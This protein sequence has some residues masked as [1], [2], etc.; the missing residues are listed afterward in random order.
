MTR[1]GLLVLGL[2]ACSASAHAGPWPTGAG[3]LYAKLS[4]QRLRST[5]YAFPDGFETRI[6]E[7]RRDDG[8]LFFAYGLTDGVTLL[9]DVPYRS[10]DLADSPDE[11]RRV[12]G[13]GDLRFG[14]QVQLGRSGPW[15]FATRGLVQAPVGDET[16]SGGLQATGSGTWEAE[17]CLG[18]GRSLWGGKGYGLLELGHQY[19][20][21]GLRDGFV[22]NFQI[23]WNTT[24]RLVLAANFHG[25]EPYST[26]AGDRTAGSFVGV[27]DRVTYA[28]YG[29]TLILKA[30]DS[31]GV[32]L[33]V[34]GAF[35][36][37]NITK[38]TAFRV[39][40]FWQR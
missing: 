3:R 24:S 35:H 11:L 19:R 15:V 4:Y 1:R 5:V 30:S 40:V 13:I 7:F 2:L 36:T 20:G 17:A 37:R 31:L 18:A 29:P 32:Q 38:G 12:G 34:D 14:L 27:G 23:G 22:Y 9:A 25:I 26:K 8:G 10:S 16:K 39:G 6:P 28:A 21:A 33:D